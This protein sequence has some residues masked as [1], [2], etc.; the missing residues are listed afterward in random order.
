MPSVNLLRKSTVQI[1]VHEAQEGDRIARIRTKVVTTPN[2][3]AIT[4]IT[5]TYQ[6]SFTVPCTTEAISSNSFK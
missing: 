2:G 3:C 5:K 6:E 1:D 4:C